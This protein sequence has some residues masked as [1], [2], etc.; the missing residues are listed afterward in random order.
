MNVSQNNYAKWEK[1]DQKKYMLYVSLWN[2]R[3]FKIIY[4]D[5]RSVITWRAIK[6]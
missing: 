2:S 6:G 4:C 5:R 1:L 3:K